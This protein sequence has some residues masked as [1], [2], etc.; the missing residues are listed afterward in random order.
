[1]GIGGLTVVAAAIKYKGSLIL[2]ASHLDKLMMTQ[3]R[4]IYG[5]EDEDSLSDFKKGYVTNQYKEKAVEMFI[6]EAEGISLLCKE[7]KSRG[8]TEDRLLRK[9]LYADGVY[10]TR[11]VLCAANRYDGISIVGYRH[12]CNVMHSVFN[13]MDQ[14]NA[15]KLYSNK[16]GEQGFIDSNGKFLSREDSFELAISTGQISLENKISA[17]KNKL[18]SEDLY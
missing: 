3:L 6:S 18:F 11:F 14:D 4:V 7:L 9:G 8:R 5:L 15:F 13:S 1:M 17:S 12:H 16:R 2:G 10:K